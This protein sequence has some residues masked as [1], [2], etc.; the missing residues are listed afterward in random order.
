MSTV[1]NPPFWRLK[2]QPYEMMKLRNMAKQSKSGMSDAQITEA[3]RHFTI[4]SEPARLRILRSLMAGPQ[5][6]SEL[7]AATGLKQGNVSK[8]LGVLYGARFVSREKEGN[9]ARYAIADADLFTL[10][11]LMCNRIERDARNQAVQLG[12][13]R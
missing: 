8:H 7:V 12:S 1:E 2:K 4:L 6:V 13:R 3:A 10:C 9:F 11:E 5:T